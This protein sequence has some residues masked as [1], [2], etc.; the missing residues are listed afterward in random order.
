MFIPSSLSALI[1]P[2]L[3]ILASLT[4]CDAA[5]ARGDSVRPVLIDTDPGL[6]DAL[7]L[8]LAWNSP[9]LTVETITT[10]AGNVGVEQATVNLLRLLAL[11]RPTPAP[12]LGVGAAQPLARPLVTAQGYHGDDGMG[13]L[14]GWPAVQVSPAPRA[15]DLIVDAA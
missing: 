13:D 14:E 12:A 1:Q 3:V 6:D 9:E 4:G 7:A 15:A 2:V 11:R 5:S 8:L 10:V